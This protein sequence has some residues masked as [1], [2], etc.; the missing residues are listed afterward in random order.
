MPFW[1]CW[2]DSSPGHLQ[3]RISSTLLS[4]ESG[5]CLFVESCGICVDTQRM[6]HP[7]H[8]ACF[9]AAL[10]VLVSIAGPARAQFDWSGHLGQQLSGFEKHWFSSWE[11]ENTSLRGMIDR[12]YYESNTLAEHDIRRINRTVERPDRSGGGSTTIHRSTSLVDADGRI[13]ATLYFNPQTGKQVQRESFKYDDAGRLLEWRPL[14]DQADVP[15]AS[16]AT[17]IYNRMLPSG[18]YQRF[19]YHD[20]GQIREWAAC[21][22]GRD[23]RSN[24][25]ADAYVRFDSSGLV[26]QFIW[27]DEIYTL[28]RDIAGTM[29]GATRTSASGR[30]SRRDFTLSMQHDDFVLREQVVTPDS[31]IAEN[32]VARDSKGRVAQY[33]IGSIDDPDYYTTV[34]WTYD[35]AGRLTSLV[36]GLERFDFQYDDAGRL[37]RVDQS[38]GTS[39]MAW[40]YDDDGRLIAQTPPMQYNRYD[41]IEE[42]EER[43]AYDDDGLLESITV[44]AEDGTVLGRISFTYEFYSPSLTRSR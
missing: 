43:Y 5:L 44:V 40:R 34:T 31:V 39:T 29:V 1:A 14:R 41:L 20:N 35:D 25:C 42:G 36:R 6:T 27:R 33:Q 10:L 15:V 2:F 37:A 19:L 30:I 12:S 21:T 3:G 32:I 22:P 26:N 17:T 13:T 23:R 24:P 7:I 16:I 9:R 18:R 28:A 11:M 38:S 8:R 4:H